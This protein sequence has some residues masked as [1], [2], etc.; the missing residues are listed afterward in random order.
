MTECTLHRHRTLTSFIP[1]LL[2]FSVCPQRDTAQLCNTQS[3]LCMRTPSLGSNRPFVYNRVFRKTSVIMTSHTVADTSLEHLQSLFSEARKSLQRALGLLSP[4]MFA[5]EPRKTNFKL[6]RKSIDMKQRLVRT[7][8]W[9]G[10]ITLRVIM[11]LVTALVV[12]EEMFHAWQCRTYGANSEKKKKRV[13]STFA[14]PSWGLRV[15]PPWGK[16]SI[17]HDTFTTLRGRRGHVKT[18]S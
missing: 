2:S 9:T 5:E 10:D 16:S 17:I 13:W 14:G 6:K 4:E 7:L 3:D 15:G 11:L 12:R 18:S 8:L 1:C